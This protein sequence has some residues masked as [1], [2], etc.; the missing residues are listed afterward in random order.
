MEGLLQFQDD[1]S[2]II[3]KAR[4]NL[5][6][7]PQER[8]TPSYVQIRLT[9]LDELWQQF[10]KTH[11]TLVR[12][13]ESKEFRSSQYY[14]KNVYDSTEECFIDCKAEFL[15]LLHSFKSEGSCENTEGKTSSSQVKLPKIIIPTFS[16]NYLEW[17]TFRDLFTSLVHNCQSLD[18][19]Q[20]MYYL[21][22]YLTG[23]AEQLLR[24]IPI[25]S[26]NYQTAWETIKSRYDN[27]K[28]LTKNI[29]QR[30]FNL[31][32]ATGESAQYLKCLIDTT[33]DCLNGLSNLG[34]NVSNW[35]VMLIFM[36]SLKL[37][38]ESR[39]QWEFFSSNNS[40]SDVLPTFE[41][42]KK[43]LTDRARALEALEANKPNVSKQQVRPKTLHVVNFKCP[44]CSEDHKLS[45]CKKFISKDS[46]SR[47]DFVRDN[48]LCFNC[49]SST[50]LARY[51]KNYIQCRT[52]KKRHHT[53]LHPVNSKPANTNA[54]NQEPSSSETGQSGATSV[55]GQVMTCFSTGRSYEQVLLATA[56]VQAK[57]QNGRNY[58]LRAL[59]DQGSQAS[60]V[61]EATVQYLNLKKV[62]DKGIDLLLGAEVYTQVLRDGIRRS[63]N[64]LTVAQFTA[65]GWVLSGG[66][67]NAKIPRSN[68]VTFHSRIDD[69][70]LLRRSW[71][72]ESDTEPTKPLLTEEEIQCEDY[73]SKTTYRDVDGR[74]VVRL[75][76]KPKDP[77]YK[78]DT[79]REIA[80]KRLN[81]LEAKLNRNT[82]LK[83]KYKEVMNEYLELQH[84]ERVS[85]PQK[86]LE[87]ALYLPHHAV[88]RSDK[89][90]TKVR[91]VFDASCKGR[92]G[93]SLNN[94]LLTGPTLQ[95][96]L[97]YIILRWRLSPI[98]L[99]ADII[100]MYR[101]AK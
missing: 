39:R 84:M 93:V 97:R 7:S 34:V 42:F 54:N 27:K 44:Y 40:S 16:G 80:E 23:E 6:K 9:N 2:D 13:S 17:V 78:H 85:D 56:L 65:L 35:D 99:A 30:L 3:S 52:C 48:H 72:L 96:D 83:N 14:V 57:A 50:H 32:N 87:T 45:S 61:T 49:F 62:S 12:E 60:F 33:C 43:F 89:D 82:E 46:E 86:Y 53:L 67:T 64:G 70:A 69:D 36:L 21:K 18:N 73:Y 91:V 51:C 11:E 74:F 88:V 68:I 66:I 79:Y 8:L 4:K 76:F 38:Q 100:K 5:K 98:C 19:V 59:L 15:S 63:P 90:T 10:N 29:L 1:I 94:N 101:Q 95:A 25:S 77:S 26:E 37:D 28:F 55:Q 75:P 31:R 81:S 92:Y 24:Q 58:T 71:E 41:E 47:R 22:G 20:K